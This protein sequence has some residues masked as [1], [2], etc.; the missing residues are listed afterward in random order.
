MIRRLLDRRCG[1]GI[2]RIGVVLPLPMLHA[3][4][5]HAQSSNAPA[6][7]TVQTA[8]AQAASGPVPPSASD[9]N[10]AIVVTGARGVRRS[11]A[12]SATPIDVITSS[13]L[14]KTGKAGLQEA[15]A[16]IL[17]SFALPSQAGGNISSIVRTATIRG[18]DSDQVLVL[19]NGKRR[20]VSAVVNVSGT[21]NTGSQAVDLNLIPM[22]AVDHI[23]VLRDGAAAQYGSDAIAGVINIIL[24]SGD[25][26][27]TSYDTG[28]AY[29]EGDGITWTTDDD[30]GFRLGN[31]GFLHLSFEG[32][33]QDH[34][35]RAEVSTLPYYYAG[36]P[37]NELPH[38]VTYSGY[39]QPQQHTLDF[40]ANM[41]KP[42]TP[43]IT[44]YAF[45]TYAHNVGMQW[46]NFR[47]PAA[48]DA[49]L[50]IFPDG[51]QP[52]EQIIQD[53]VAGTIGLKGDDLFGWR[54]D[55]STTYGRDYASIYTLNTVNS[56]YGA[57]SPTKFYDGDWE[58]VEITNNFD[59]THPFHVPYLAAPL[60]VAAGL[61][62]RVDSY[63][64]G[65]GEPASYLNGGIP[66]LTGPNAG[67][68][69][70]SPGAQSQGG[71][72][73]SETA[74]L[75]RNNI[76]GYIDLETKILPQWQVGLAGRLEHYNDFGNDK[77]GKA[78]TRYEITKWL[79]VRG[80]IGNGFRAPS[81]GE[82]GFQ[83]QSTSFY[84]GIPYNSVNLPVY[85]VG[86]QA[87]GAQPLRPETSIDY[88]A[89][90][91]L[92]PMRRMSITVDGYQIGIAN[93]IVESG[94]IGLSPSGVLSPGVAELLSGLGLQ[95]V[96]AAR[97][98]LNGARTRTRGADIVADYRT[99]LD[100]YG[101]ML[102]SIGLNLNETEILG[103][104]PLAR[105]TEFGTQV[106][107]AMAQHDLTET[108]P[109]N[110]LTLGANYTI[111]R[112]NVVL[113]EHRW[114]SL[115]ATST[116]TGGDSFLSPHWTTDLD[117]GY[118]LLDR[119]RVSVGAQNLFNAYPDRANSLN[120]SANTFNGAQI[121]NAN[122][123]Y[124][125]SGGF[126]YV[127]LNYNF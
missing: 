11:V 6:P 84:K 34:T 19:I 102:W 86:A 124:G 31:D 25:H 126:Y 18:L 111:G 80:S 21:V 93:R 13:D 35:G 104:S 105:S 123:P 119:L 114:G 9:N 99:D 83:A 73:P 36:S 14:K 45:G 71:F 113:R 96:G 58:A 43:G 122:S 54:W 37:E 72:L 29:G 55:L 57:A 23:E 115:V 22:A 40:A 127:H 91:V 118:M 89:G 16:D 41:E 63:A 120:F 1:G 24:K 42:L 92:N 33:R 20:H 108:N 32:V 76:G 85:S 88:S 79:A 82:E 53:D 109:K 52:R 56:T 39:G 4:L 15:L 2:L 125:I 97:Y 77:I 68:F 47:Q 100:Q 48:N 28:G 106:L 60:N 27:G 101:H 10:E 67:K 107:N 59:L 98:F 70:D 69:L 110:N 61:E 75:W 112:F 103:L 95:G 3:G 121:Y 50:A 7:S 38:R 66:I 46:E 65:P 87:L 90:L 17:P 26:G 81:L 74:N 30:I 116:V 62:Q 12:S 78:S 117:L 44:L 8:A 5:A 49:V 64:I 51:Y 94:Y